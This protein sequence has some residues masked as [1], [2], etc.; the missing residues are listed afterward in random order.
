MSGNEACD[1][2]CPEAK[3]GLFLP[4]LSFYHREDR[5]SAGNNAISAITAPGMQ[6]SPS[7]VTILAVQTVT[8]LV[9]RATTEVA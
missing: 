9:R 7:A 4:A 8:R 2:L 5:G 6:C 1:L 3:A